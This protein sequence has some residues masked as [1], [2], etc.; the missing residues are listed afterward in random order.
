M[1]RPDAESNRRGALEALID[2]QLLLQRAR[3][4]GLEKDSEIR[5]ALEKSRRHLLAQ[6]AIDTSANTDVS[7]REVKAFYAEHPEL[8]EGRKVYA[9]RRFDLERGVLDTRLKAKLNTAGPQGNVGAILTA[10]GIQYAQSTEVRP[11]ESLPRTMLGEVVRMSVGDILLY[12]RASR[13]VLMQL[14]SSTPEPVPFQDAM[15]LLRSHL[16]EIKRREHAGRLLR[17]LR[18]E[19]S[20]EYATRN[21]AALPATELADGKSLVGEPPAQKSLQSRQMTLVR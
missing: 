18:S 6:A 3:D 11:A 20:I 16:A 1:A 15:P 9:F 13:T 12:R 10:A 7:I 5:M 2:E 4:E 21:A 19:A 17:R 8:F 14:V